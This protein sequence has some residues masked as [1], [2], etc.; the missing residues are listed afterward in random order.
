MGFWVTWMWV[1]I[2][3]RHL[4]VS[5]WE[6]FL[7]H[8]NFSL[9]IC[10]VGIPTLQDSIWI[11]KNI[12]KAPSTV[13]LSRT[14]AIINR[15]SS[16]FWQAVFAKTV[17]CQ[18]LHCREQLGRTKNVTWKSSSAN[19]FTQWFPLPLS[20]DFWEKKYN[21]E[22]CNEYQPMWKMSIVT[23]LRLIL[24]QR[25]YTICS[26]KREF[27]RCSYLLWYTWKW[28]S[29]VTIFTSLFLF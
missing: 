4:L 18:F 3:I 21:L 24:S 22:V 7:T 1:Q 2:L 14:V 28:T 25:L 5:S 15:G 6:N 16:R 19:A 20:F 10:K 29:V 27:S 8:L 9:L 26:L 23:L 12:F 13:I 17:I 11:S